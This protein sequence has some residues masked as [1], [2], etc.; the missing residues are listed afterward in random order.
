MSDDF[1]PAPVPPCPHC[2][3]PPRRLK[4]LNAWNALL[5]QCPNHQCE[6]FSRPF[7]P[8]AWANYCKEHKNGNE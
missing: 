6:I 4:V 7:S 2:S 5:L 1:N 8:D 3:T